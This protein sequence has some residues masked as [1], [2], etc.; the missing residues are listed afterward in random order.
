MINVGVISSYGDTSCGIHYHTDNLSQY[1]KYI[2]NITMLQRLDLPPSVNYKSVPFWAPNTVQQIPKDI[3]LLWVQ[4]ET[5][6]NL[7]L[8]QISNLA[9]IE[10]IPIVMTLHEVRS[11]ENKFQADRVI[12]HFPDLSNGKDIIHISHG[13]RDLTFRIS[14]LKARKLLGLPQDKQIFTMPGRLETRKEIEKLI[15]IFNDIP[16]KEFY[17]VGGVPQTNY[18][19]FRRYVRELELSAGKNVHIISGEPIPQ[20]LLDLYCQAADFLVFNDVPSYYSTSGAAQAAW[21]LNKIALSPKNVLLFDALNDKNSLKFYNLEH[22]RD[23]I[24][25]IGDED[26][27]IE[28][29][30]V[31][32]EQFEQ[33]KFP[34]VAQRYAKLF[35]KT[36]EEY[37]K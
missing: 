33:M 10:K 30:L 6:L 17:F 14:K 4:H 36:I 28:K 8:T 35:Q 22:L 29:K 9:K 5:G 13:C 16:E 31:L 1:L 24:A 3:D 37:K 34:I 25:S 21:E 7:P 20:L 15:S 23:I 18:Y 19:Q 2:V 12:V 32:M 11:G 26:D 27:Y